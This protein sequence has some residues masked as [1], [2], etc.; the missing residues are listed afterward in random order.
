[1]NGTSSDEHGFLSNDEIMALSALTV[2][3]LLIGHVVNEEDAHRSTIVGGRDSS[4]T[5]LARSI[6]L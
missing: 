4:E 6:P 1:M 2:E 3:A 5:F